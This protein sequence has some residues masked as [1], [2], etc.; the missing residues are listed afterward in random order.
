MKKLGRIEKPKDSCLIVWQGS[1]RHETRETRPPLL[2]VPRMTRVQRLGTMHGLRTLLQSRG[3]PSRR[4]LHLKARSNSK[5]PSDS[6]PAG[7]PDL[8]IAGH[9]RHHHHQQG[10]LHRLPHHH[11]TMMLPRQEVSSKRKF[12]TLTHSPSLQLHPNLVKAC[13]IVCDGEDHLH[14]MNDFRN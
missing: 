14:R 9:H 7:L 2:R 11:L 5:T 13:G 3:K 10:S 8:G 4:I 12:S 6:Q 1:H